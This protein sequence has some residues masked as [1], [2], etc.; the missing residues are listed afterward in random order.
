MPKGAVA[1]TVYIHSEEISSI[2]Y[3]ANRVRVRVKAIGAVT[4]PGAAGI[5]KTGKEEVAKGVTE[6]SSETDL[7][8]VQWTPSNPTTLGT[9]QVS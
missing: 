1:G 7:S 6:D 3:V 5:N 4:T 2:T 9:R 8:K